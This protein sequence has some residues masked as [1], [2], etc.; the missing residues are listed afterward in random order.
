[1]K[2]GWGYR[3]GRE[4]NAV[5]VNAIKIVGPHICM[6]LSFHDGMGMKSIILEKEKRQNGL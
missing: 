1:M 4:R 5:D 2:K 3:N 6:P